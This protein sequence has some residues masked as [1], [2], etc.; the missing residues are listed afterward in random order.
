MVL[1]GGETFSGIERIARGRIGRTEN[2]TKEKEERWKRRRLPPP[3]RVSRAR[4]KN[5]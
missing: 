1:D 4:S 2:T 3:T 5:G